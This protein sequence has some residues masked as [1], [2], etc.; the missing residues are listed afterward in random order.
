M[1]NISTAAAVKY[2]QQNPDVLC[3]PEHASYCPLARA[4]SNH[5]NCD[6]FVMA[7]K[8]KKRGLSASSVK[9]H[10]WQVRL[11]SWFDERFKKPVA[12]SCVL[13][14]AKKEGIL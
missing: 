4:L 5:N 7:S 3:F 13:T 1:R 6:V 8:A 12:A 11:V 14:A 9:L 10:P 2:L